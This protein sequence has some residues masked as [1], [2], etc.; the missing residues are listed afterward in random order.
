M[1][2]RDRGYAGLLHGEGVALGMVAAARLSEQ[3]T[4]LPTGTADRIAALLMRWHLPVKPPKLSL[5]HI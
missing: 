5:I 1:C 3:M 2:I 4:G